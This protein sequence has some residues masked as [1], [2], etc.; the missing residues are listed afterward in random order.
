M[1]T[2]S[3][4]YNQ[5]PRTT[6]YVSAKQ[7]ANRESNE[8][9][10]RI[11]VTNEIT[12]DTIKSRIKEHECELVYALIGGV[13]VPDITFI[14]DKL[15]LKRGESQDLHV[16]IALVTMYPVKREDALKMCRAHKS[17]DEYAVPRNTKFTYAGWLAHHTKQ[18]YKLDQDASVIH[19]EYGTLPMDSYDEATCWS[20]LK[21]LKKFGTPEIKQRFDGYYKAIDAFK[22]AK[23][24]QSTEEDD[25][26]P[27]PAISPKFCIVNRK[28][29]P[30]D[31]VAAIDCKQI[32]DQSQ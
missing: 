23:L 5:F 28:E 32:I 13:E 3:K 20:V 17:G 21:M 26:G 6:P 4:N 16:H 2:Y 11:D 29:L 30:N 27:M 19:Y 7:R 22:Q 15:D 8:W 9:D 25:I 18:Q 24:E 1:R 31:L 12:P 10:I 14:S